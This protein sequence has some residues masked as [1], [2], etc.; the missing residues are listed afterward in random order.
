MREAQLLVLMHGGEKDQEAARGHRR[1]KRRE[2]SSASTAMYE[3]E[4]EEEEGAPVVAMEDDDSVPKISLLLQAMYTT[5]PKISLCSLREADDHVRS[6]CFDCFMSYFERL[7]AQRTLDDRLAHL[8]ARERVRVIKIPLCGAIWLHQLRCHSAI[9]QAQFLL[10]QTKDSS[11]QPTQ[12][13]D[14]PER[15]S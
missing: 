13:Q 7:L 14:H 2:C 8:V 10:A 9:Q 1:R 11:T 4:E 15:S 5:V 6:Y 12:R 3:E